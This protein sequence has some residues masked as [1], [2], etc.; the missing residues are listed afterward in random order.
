MSFNTKLILTLLLSLVAFNKIEAQKVVSKN[1]I[2]FLDNGDKETLNSITPPP[3]TVTINVKLKDKSTK[4][5]NS[6]LEVNKLSNKRKKL[7]FRSKRKKTTK[8][9]KE[10]KVPCNKKK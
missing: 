6:L 7:R 5:V 9:Y 4:E 2:Q 10:T 1:G 8:C 3:N